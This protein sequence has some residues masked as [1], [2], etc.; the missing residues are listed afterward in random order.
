MLL[1][2]C[3]YVVTQNA[4]REILRDVDILI[5]DNHIERIGKNL[6]GTPVINCKDRI[7]MPGLINCH[8]H[9]GMSFMRGISDDK[10]LGLWLNDIIT[11][12]H[13]ASKKEIEQGA[14]IGLREAIRTG[15][16][17]VCDHYWEH[18]ASPK[19]AAKLGIRLYFFQDFFTAHHEL[20]ASQIPKLL[21]D[22]K[23]WP[24][25][26]KLGLAPHSIYGTTEK[27]LRH[28][29]TYASEHKLLLHTHVAETR[30]E[31]VECKAKTGK[32]P[33]EYLESLGFLNGDVMVA[34]AVWLTK[35][36]LDT[37]AKRKASVV[38]CP[39]SNM[40]LAGGGVMPLREMQERGINVALGTDSTASN[41]S[42][43]MFREMHTAALLHKHHYWDG[44]AADAQSVL[45]M[46]TI[47]GAK[48]I[49]MPDLGSIE[50][51]KLA[52]IITLDA[53]DENL[54]PVDEKRIV[55][56]IVYAANGLN[57]SEVIVDG[58]I[59][60]RNKQLEK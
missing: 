46:A 56:H 55:S 38:H 19:I 51:G 37:L 31:R 28:A 34:H 52:D 41:N 20:D 6:K 15:T 7:V 21:P 50:N 58:N 60:V 42:L 10:E 27:F 14:C 12:E 17:T 25:T 4:K 23:E 30:K 2:N 45:D 40:K 49:H 1:K 9:I 13:K 22:A 39:Q 5:K 44:A 35:G 53:T 43:D 8:T 47:N 26:I 36:E 18:D 59:V 32:L 33:I 11:A 29:R 24:G 16:T 48:A 3:R 57:V 54:Q